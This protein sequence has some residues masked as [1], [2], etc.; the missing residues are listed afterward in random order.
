VEVRF[1]QATA[2]LEGKHSRPKVKAPNL[3]GSLGFRQCRSNAL[4]VA[5]ISTNGLRFV[6]GRVE[7][8]H[9]S[10]VGRLNPER[11]CFVKT[12]PLPDCR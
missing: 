6:L 2:V 8:T 5:K 12:D 11:G 10:L 1:R 7:I 4:P 9:L 3:F